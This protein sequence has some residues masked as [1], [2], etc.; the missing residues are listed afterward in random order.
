MDQIPKV[1]VG[2]L[3]FK[4]GKILLGKRK[5]SHGEGEYSC[6]GG[7]LDYEEYLKD[8]AIREVKEECNINIKNLKFVCLVDRIKSSPKHYVTAIF[9]S[10]FDGGELKIMEPDKCESLDWYDLDNL[11]S[12]MFY[13]AMKGID[14]YKTGR[15]FF[16]I[17][18]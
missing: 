7:H 14:S 1:G 4:E 6:P 15:N 3:I 18:K 17:E 2:V 5:G 11:P 13:Y 12:P 9:Y 16:D 8:C 10:E